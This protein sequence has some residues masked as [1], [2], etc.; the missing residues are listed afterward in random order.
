MKNDHI[1]YCSNTKMILEVLQEDLWNLGNF[2]ASQFLR[3]AITEITEHV[4]ASPS[5]AI[6]TVY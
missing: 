6:T 3:T 2:R 5:L 1:Y 4:L